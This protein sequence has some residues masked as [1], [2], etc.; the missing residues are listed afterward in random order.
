MSPSFLLATYF[1]NISG[2]YGGIFTAHKD[3]KVMGTTAIASAALC[4]VLDLVLVPFHF[5]LYGASFATIAA[6]FVVNEYRRIK[7]RAY[8]ALSENRREQFATL[9]C[10]A[11]TL[12]C[13]YVYASMGGVLLLLAGVVI[14]AGFFFI[15]NRAVIMRMLVLV[16]Q[17]IRNKRAE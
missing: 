3:T 5:G 2:F 12:V 11:A 7:V 6:M 16:Q 14:A 8:A 15:A 10:L 13:F 4:L 1:S 9:L 17:V